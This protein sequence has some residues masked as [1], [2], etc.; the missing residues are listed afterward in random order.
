MLTP[1]IKYRFELF[2]GTQVAILFGSLIIP[3]A[4]NDLVS[5]ILFY[6]NVIIGCLLIG[7]NRKFQ[8]KLIIIFS[9][10]GGILIVSPWFW[11]ELKPLDYF[12]FVLFFIF[13]VWI[14][15]SIIRSLWHANTVDKTIIFGL[16][17]GYISLGFLGLFIFL[18]LELLNPGSFSGLTTLDGASNNITEP[19]IYFSYI[20]LMTIG[21][22]EI[23]PLTTLAQKATIL[24]GL[25]GQFYLVII[26]AIIVGKFLNQNSNLNR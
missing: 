6:L 23:L 15:V 19:L 4:V 12:Q 14:A 3:S 13:H 20:T 10:L 26:T 5:S 1:L 18:S 7:N 24:I 16:M 22:G 25:I 9:A 17:S 21:Y 11:E 2:L 8:I